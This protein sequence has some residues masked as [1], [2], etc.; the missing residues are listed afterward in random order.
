T[1]LLGGDEYIN[2]VGLMILAFG[3]MFEAPLLLF[4]LGLVGVVSVEQLRRHRRVAILVI[5]VVAAVITP[6]QDPYTMTFLSL[7]LYLFYE[8]TVAL[9]AL[10][11]KR[12]ASI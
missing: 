2:F 5:V 7:P 10:V 4:F 1:P 6:S 9:L 3:I 12:R 8:I 11:K